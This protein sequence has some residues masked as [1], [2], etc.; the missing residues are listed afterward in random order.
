MSTKDPTLDRIHE[1][2]STG[3]PHAFKC[4]YYAFVDNH[5]QLER[6]VH[7]VLHDDRANNQREFF[8]LDCA[9]AINII[10]DQ[11][12]LQSAFKYEQIFYIS[13]D[14]LITERRQRAKQ[15]ELEKEDVKRLV[16]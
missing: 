13:P 3:V 6:I 5:D 11:A 7:N 8:S 10:R 4:E 12:N 9:K 14:D 1:L 16:L 15:L 2:N